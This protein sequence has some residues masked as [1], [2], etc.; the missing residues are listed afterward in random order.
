MG[1]GVC[2]NKIEA[3]IVTL[4]SLLLLNVLDTYASCRE[5]ELFDRG[6]EY[7]LSYQP[8]K[9]AETFKMSIKEFPDSFAKDAVM[10]WLGKSLIQLKS[11]EDARKVFSEIK[12]QFPESPFIQHVDRE[13]EK[14]GGNEAEGNKIKAGV[15]DA[16][17][18][19]DNLEARLAEA[20]EKAR[21]IG[22][23]L[24]K[25]IEDRDKL[26][27]LLEQEKKKTEETRVKLE[28]REVELKSLAAKLEG[29]KNWKEIDS[30]LKLLRDEKGNLDSEIQRLKK[31]KTQIGIERDELKD[32]I[33]RHEQKSEVELSDAVKVKNDLEV[34]LAEVEEKAQLIG[35][36]LSKAIEERDKLRLLLEEEKKKTEEMRVKVNELE[37]KEIELKTLLAKFEEQQIKKQP[38]RIEPSQEQ[39]KPQP[40]VKESKTVTPLPHA[41]EAKPDGKSIYSVQVSVFKNEANAVAFAKEFKKAGYDAFTYKSTTKDKGILYRVLIGRFINMKEAAELANSIRAKEK[42]DVVIFCE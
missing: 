3:I 37:G 33:K 7:Y 39:Q 21:L 15:G 36:D 30:N 32:K 40:A 1:K 18:I 19:K 41:F 8:E 6:Y 20:E 2:K 14:K 35:I 13:L 25:A 29:Q 16:V 38:E 5:F 9:A 26:G 31:E 12:Q 24:S 4:L 23:D 22:K 17:K 42:I 27:S 10:F 11:F 28:G 34:R